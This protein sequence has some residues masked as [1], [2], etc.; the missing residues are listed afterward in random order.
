MNHYNKV[1]IDFETRSEVNI[2]TDGAYKYAHHN[3]TGIYCLAYAFDDE[4]PKIWLWGDTFPSE[5]I[6]HVRL[7]RPVYAFNAEFELLIWNIVLKHHYRNLPNLS[8]E[9][10]FCTAAQGRANSLPASLE[11]QARALG[12]SLNKS[13]E[14]K[15][16]IRQY[17]AN[18]I[19]WEDIPEKDQE[20]FIKYCIDDVNVE[21]LVSGCLRDL[22]KT[23]WQDY[24]NIIKMNGRGIHVDIEFAEAAIKLSEEVKA[25]VKAK[26]LALTDGKIDSATDRKKRDAFLL[27]LLTEE[28]IKAITVNDKL[29]F[30]KEKRELLASFHDLHPKVKRYLDLLY[31]AGSSTISK[32][33][34]MLRSHVNHRIFGAFQFN[35]ATTGRASSK[36]VQLQNMKRPIFNDEEALE[37]IEKVI[38]GEDID[39]PA[40]TLAYL[41]RPTIY[42]DDGMTV[43]DYSSIEYIVLSWLAENQSAIDD[44]INGVDAYK[45][46]ATQI[47]NCNMDEVTKDQRQAAKIV[48]L[49]AGFGGGKGAVKSMAIGYGVNFTDEQCQKLIDGYRQTHKKEVRLWSDIKTAIH[50]AVRKPH[51]EFYAGKCIFESDRH[52]L[53]LQL[54]SGRFLR[55]LEPKYEFVPPP[56]DGDLIPAVTYKNTKTVPSTDRNDWPRAVLSHII[57]TEN[58]CQAIANDLLRDAIQQCE[59]QKLEP[60]MMVHDEIVV[61]DDKRK[62]LHKIMTTP[63]SWAEDMPLKAEGEFRYMYGK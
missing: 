46:L 58:I 62:E 40:D 23:E 25:D 5:L 38:A 15:R 1:S 49:A 54:P 31:E 37:L 34:A 45:V 33:D 19:L 14:G 51:T 26:L 2:I 17:S 43:M 44:Y 11:N 39:N 28:Q 9:Q 63:P 59:E 52:S 21:R 16:L 60:F 53:W 47:F 56:W 30:G 32:Y 41:I 35:S 12:T 55:Y 61:P 36:L 29:S 22:S 50:N 27:P 57:A 18:N 3:S 13:V 6:N 4:E 48:I 7:N 8:I 42:L 20:L 24:R 10:L